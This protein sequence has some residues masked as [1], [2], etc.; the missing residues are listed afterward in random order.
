MYTVYNYKTKKALLDAV[1]FGANVR[2]YQPG[3]FPAQ[4]DGAVSLE[5]PHYPAPHRWWASAVL[6]DGIIVSV[7]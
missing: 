5:G 1:K 2:T 4:T 7:K 6:K 3:F